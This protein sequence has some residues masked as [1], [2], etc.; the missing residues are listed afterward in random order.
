MMT[1]M[2][3]I[4]FAGLLPKIGRY[5]PTESIAGFLFVLGAIVTVPVNAAAALASTAA[6][7]TLIGGVTMTVTAIT[8][9]F[10]GMIAGLALKL[11]L[12]IIG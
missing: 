1:L 9:P 5:I 3:I 8:D 10:I 6:N 11:F 4:L 7:G 12:P 2:A